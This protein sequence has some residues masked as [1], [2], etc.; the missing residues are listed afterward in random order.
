MEDL[1]Q[2]KKAVENDDVKEVV[3]L[4]KPLRTIGYNLPFQADDYITQMQINKTAKR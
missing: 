1:S 2:L 4:A 3:R